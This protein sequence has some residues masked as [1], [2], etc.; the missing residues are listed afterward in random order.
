MFLKVVLTRP[1]YAEQLDKDN[2]LRMIHVRQVWE[3]TNLLF[4]LYIH[5]IQTCA[6]IFGNA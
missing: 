5:Q 2:L 4:N 3:D 1:L 6:V